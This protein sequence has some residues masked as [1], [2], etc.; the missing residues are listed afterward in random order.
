M[1]V[2][3]LSRSEFTLIE[4]LMFRVSVRAFLII[5]ST[6]SYIAKQVH[7]YEWTYPFQPQDNKWTHIAFQVIS[8]Y[9]F[10]RRFNNVKDRS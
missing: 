9:N 5:V 10:L 2:L 3:N 7:E 1:S 8:G 6:N 4:E